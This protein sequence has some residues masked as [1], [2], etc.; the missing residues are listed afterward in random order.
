[1]LRRAT[2]AWLVFLVVLAGAHPALA[3]PKVVV[4]IKPLY[5]LVAGVMAGVGRPQ[6]LVKGSASPHLYALKP[7]DLAALNGADIVFRAS[8]A[9]EPFSVRLTQALPRQVE[10]VTLEEAPGIALL[11]RRMGVSFEAAG[12]GRRHA[13]DAGR[14]NA[15]DGHIWLDPD[16]AKA[17]VDRIE[18]ALS[19]KDPANA[20]AFKTNATALKRQLD[21]LRAELQGA[22]EPLAGKPYVVAH[23][24]FQY[25]ERRYGLNVV[26]AISISPEVAP[27]AKRLGELRRKILSLGAV[28]VFAE[29]QVDRRL[30]DN[31]IEGT[32]ARTGTLDPEG[33]ALE[34]DPNLYFTLMRKLAEDLRACLLPPA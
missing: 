15:F 27:S 30:I 20:D 7:S 3:A 22:L 2:S 12:D 4:T 11:E 14:A 32:L 21:A 8:P 26:G 24:A 31:L 18:Q 23:D 16:N 9:T 33:F 34:P 29:P 6:M 5:A 13:H 25:L 28:C 17:M 1:M 10:L 19:G